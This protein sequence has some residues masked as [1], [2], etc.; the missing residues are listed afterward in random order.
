MGL[1]EKVLNRYL[2]ACRT[3][4]IPQ[5]KLTLPHAAALREEGAVEL[6]RK[7]EGV[8]NSKSRNSS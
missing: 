1:G 2:E 4:K 5:E 7:H 8:S 6:C 3:Q